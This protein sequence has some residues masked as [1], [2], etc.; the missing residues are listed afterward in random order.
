MLTLILSLL[1][2]Q[3]TTPAYAE[4]KSVTVVQLQRTNYKPEKRLH[5]DLN[6]NPANCEIQRQKPFDAYY[7]DNDTGER[8][9]KFS[10]DSVKY[11]G[12]KFDPSKVLPHE[13]ELSFGAFEEIQES[14]GTH[15]RLLFRIESV[16][17]KCEAQAEVTYKN[18][19][20]QLLR[21]E[22]EVKKILG[23]PSGV[24]WVRLKGKSERGPVVDCV[25]GGC[26]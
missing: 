12:P 13:A 10:S 18:K 4:A 24:K 15:A 3:I 11:F 17:G 25:T 14:L 8:I 7:V 1:A 9:E 16:N 2:Y 26:E 21:I 20:Y 5:Y 23:F 22:L 6:Y 19:R